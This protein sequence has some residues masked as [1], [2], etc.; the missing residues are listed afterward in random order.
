METKVPAFGGEVCV[1][2]A[3]VRYIL[4]NEAED[5]RDVED[6]R[7]K[8]VE[9]RRGDVQ[10]LTDL[11]GAEVP[12]HPIREQ[13]VFDVVEGYA[14]GEGGDEC[15]QVE[16]SGRRHRE[17]EE[18]PEKD[19]DGFC[20]ARR[21]LEGGGRFSAGIVGHDILPPQPPPKVGVGGGQR[22]G[23]GREYA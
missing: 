2:T 6:S 14:V 18:V 17:E 22:A 12:V 3:R 15:A 20:S 1:S 4:Q 16:G 13:P 8:I 11:R 9:I 19:H 23:S 10:R 5:L 7:L 21:R